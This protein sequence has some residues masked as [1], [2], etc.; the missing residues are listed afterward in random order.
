MKSLLS[1]LLIGGLLLQSQFCL[2]QQSESFGNY[3]VHYNVINA[4]MIPAQVAQGYGIKRSSNRA[5]VNI[6]I[7][8]S[9][10]G[11]DGYGTA[12]EAD[13][14]TSAVNLTGQRRAVEMREI[15]E[16]DGAIYYIGE[17]PIANLETYNFNV[18]ILVAGD[19]KPL[20]LSFRQ[21]FYTEKPPKN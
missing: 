17:L 1:F 15:K 7:M 12:L 5:L 9:A 10:G 6:T 4:D 19:P 11:E 8:D 21:Q 3:V 18:T 16:P 2:A 20:E 14:K 13:V